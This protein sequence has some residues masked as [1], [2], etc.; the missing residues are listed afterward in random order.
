[1]S[2]ALVVQVK[3]EARIGKKRNKSGTVSFR[4][5]LGMVNGKREQPTFPTI[6]V[7]LAFKREADAE[8]RAKNPLALTEIAL[9]TRYSV[10]NALE[11][12]KP[13]GATIDEAVEFF[14]QTRQA[15]KACRHVSRGDRR[16]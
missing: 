1:M 4:V 14:H 16:V 10:L 7:A 12:L 6:E 5:D 15:L 11:R 13:Y 2:H 9:A 3:T 8:I